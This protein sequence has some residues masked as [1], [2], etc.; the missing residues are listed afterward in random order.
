MYMEYILTARQM[1]ESDSTAIN[2]YGIESL[3]LMERAAYETAK[4]IVESYGTDISVGVMA[5][6]G[7]NGGDGIAIARILS[8]KSIHTEINMIGD[9]NKLT[10]ETA[11]QLDTA[12]KLNIPIYYGLEIKHTYILWA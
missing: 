3:V 7:N 1:K 4:I 6:S 5:G 12:K 8:E 9:T 10:K 2:E 11:T